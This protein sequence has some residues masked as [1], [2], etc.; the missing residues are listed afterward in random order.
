MHAA[1]VAQ[2]RGRARVSVM[3]MALS[4]ITSDMDDKDSVHVYLTSSE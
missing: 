3:G 1:G 4:V 2:W